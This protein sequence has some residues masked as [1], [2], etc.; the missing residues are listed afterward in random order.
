MRVKLIG[1]GFGE[2]VVALSFR[3][4]GAE[5]EIFHP[6]DSEGIQRACAS[7][8]DLISIHSPPYLHK[9]HVD[10]ALDHGNAVLCDK[11]FGLG[12]EQ[13]KAM[14]DRAKS[15][16]LLNFIN[17]EFRHQPSRLKMRELLKAG[18]IG[19]PTHLSYMMIGAGLRDRRH[20]WLFD[21]ALGGGWIRTYGS[22]IVDMLRWMLDAEI[23]EAN[24]IRRIEVKQRTDRE[25]QVQRCTAEDGFSAWI[26]MSNGLAVGVDSAFAAAVRIPPRIVLTG[27]EGALELVSE[28]HVTLRK[29]GKEDEVFHFPPPPGD[30]HEPAL[31][32]YLGELL[33]ALR[34]GRQIAP[35]F[36]DGVAMAEAMD[37]LRAGPLID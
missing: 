4:H 17:L 22:H 18:A 37:K 33:K 2:R 10:W 6:R 1:T 23:A 36:D 5:V 34:D 12:A 16:G 29:P 13:S 35:S 27:S 24:A 30:M 7:G 20:G 14:R 21:D 32:P 28:L 31:T 9:Q 3:I 15:L 8:A 11:P 26:R 25:G 19:E